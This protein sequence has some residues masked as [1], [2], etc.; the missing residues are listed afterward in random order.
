[1]NEKIRPDGIYYDQLTPWDRAA[2]RQAELQGVSQ[3]TGTRIIHFPNNGFP[4]IFEPDQGLVHK[5]GKL[6]IDPTKRGIDA[7][8]NI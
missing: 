4:V 1:M 8:L 7:L 2:Q 3:S 5:K 6:V